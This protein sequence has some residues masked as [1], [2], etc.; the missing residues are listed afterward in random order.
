MNA[1]SN[2]SFNIILSLVPSNEIVP[3]FVVLNVGPLVSTP[4]RPL[5]LKSFM[6]VPWPAYDFR[7][8][9]STH[10]TSPSVTVFGE[11]SHLYKPTFCCVIILYYFR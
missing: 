8:A 4:L 2:V 1:V 11:K 5:P 10:N 6:V 7:F 3:A 9:A